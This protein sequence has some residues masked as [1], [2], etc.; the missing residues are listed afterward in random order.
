[1]AFP[2]VRV[3]FCNQMID[4]PSDCPLVPN[5]LGQLDN[6]EITKAVSPLEK[7]RVEQ[8]TKALAEIR[9]AALSPILEEAPTSPNLRFG[10][11]NIFDGHVNQNLQ[12][13]GAAPFSEEEW[14]QI[15]EAEWSEQGDD[16]AQDSARNLSLA[17]IAF[18]RDD[19]TLFE[20]ANAH[21]N[22]ECHRN[23]LQRRL[24]AC[25]AIVKKPR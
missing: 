10:F 16:E 14:A 6:R 17:K 19:L 25:L 20:H 24:E 7:K 9:F 15:H 4:L 21:V 5:H 12:E 22:K 13:I 2:T 23:D 1:M 11:K 3:A 8:K 18:R